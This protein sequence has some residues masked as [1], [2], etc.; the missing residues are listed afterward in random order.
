MA[1]KKKWTRW[2]LPYCADPENHVL[3]TTREGVFW[4]RKRTKTVLNEALARNADL[5]RIAGPAARRVVQKLRPFLRGL[6]T[7]RVTLRISNG[8]R[9]A[10]KEKNKLD[11][12]SLQGLEMQRNH[13]MDQLLR[14]SYTVVPGEKGLSLTIDLFPDC[15]KKQNQLVTHFYFEAVLVHGDVATGH[16][17]RVDSTESALYAFGGELA[18][19]CVLALPL[20]AEQPWMVLLKVSCL[21]GHELAMHPRHYGMKVV[22]SGVGNS[23]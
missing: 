21:E 3:V 5:S 15:V 23:G 22:A 2:D 16:D 6:D 9:K 8:L 17:L 12:S 14:A 7:G 1:P 13:S 19:A 4:R 11:Y 10:L 20:P 18:E